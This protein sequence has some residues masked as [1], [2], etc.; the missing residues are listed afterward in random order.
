MPYGNIANRFGVDLQT[1][2]ELRDMVSR[3]LY[4]RSDIVADFCMEQDKVTLDFFYVYCPYASKDAPLKQMEQAEKE[5]NELLTAE[6]AV[7]TSIY[8]AN[9][10]DCCSGKQQL[11]NMLGML[12]ADVADDDIY[13]NE[14]THPKMMM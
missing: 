5:E 14:D 12:G 10:P 4:N 6:D 8:L 2:G 3:Q 7:Q 11:N 9:A 1:D 13:H